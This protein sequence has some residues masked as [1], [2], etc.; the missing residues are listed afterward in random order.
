MF[1]AGTLYCRARS[2][3]AWLRRIVAKKSAV[4]TKMLKC[5]F[6]C[7][8]PFGTSSESNPGP[9]ARMWIALTVGRAAR[10][11]Q[12]AHVRQVWLRRR[13]CGSPAASRGRPVGADEEVGDEGG[14]AAVGELVGVAD[15]SGGGF[16]VNI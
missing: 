6:G 13:M 4:G 16:D 2:G 15:D 3:E 8:E 5:S 7:G 9:S 12:P 1:W 10:A 14:P 11:L